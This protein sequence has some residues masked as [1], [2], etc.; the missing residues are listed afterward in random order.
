MELRVCLDYS[1]VI[2]TFHLTFKFHIDGDALENGDHSVSE[3]SD[4]SPTPGGDNLE[5]I[6][7]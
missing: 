6:F 2:L 1:V 4:N 5:D 7:G 3:T